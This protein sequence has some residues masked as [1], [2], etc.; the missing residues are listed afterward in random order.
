MP[1]IVWILNNY[2]PVVLAGAEFAA[3]RINKWLLTNGCTV[4]VY[5]QS[6][7]VYPNEFEGVLIKPMKPFDCH[8]MKLE[9]DTILVSQLWATRAA[10]PL[11]DRHPGC[12]Y[13]EFVHYVDHTVISPYP[14]TSR[15][16]SLVYNSIDTKQRSLAIGSWLA[17]KPSFVI[18]PLIDPVQPQQQPQKQK[19]WI[20]LVNFNK[21]KGADIFN[22]L[23]ARDTSRKYVGIKGSH[24]TQETPHM[25]V[26]L[27]NPTMNMEH[28]WEKTR[29]LLILSTYETWSMVA[30]EAMLRGIPVVAANHI[31]ALKENCGDAAVYVNRTCIDECLSA[32]EEIESKYAEYSENA[33]A[34]ASRFRFTNHT[35]LAAIFCLDK[36]QGEA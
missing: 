18:P 3:H 34:Q 25:A 20:T 6:N 15:D 13:I 26:E 36:Q 14:W 19:E 28:V 4:T 21:D 24:G 33:A 27:L 31:P 10:R 11:F 35:D 8:T 23:A 22:Q 17:A 7:E 1:N 30:S 12:K 9:A 5:I 32:L 2:P 16:F 29:I